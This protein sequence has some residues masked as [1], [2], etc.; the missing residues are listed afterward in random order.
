[1]GPSKRILDQLERGRST[2][3][4]LPAQPP[5]RH[6]VY[7]CGLVVLVMAL[8]TGVVGW[9]TDSAPRSAS[10]PVRDPVFR[11]AAAPVVRS[12]RDAERLAAA[13]VNEPLQQHVAAQ[14]RQ[15]ERMAGAEA[16]AGAGAAPVVTTR[17]AARAAL[18][19]N[20]TAPARTAVGMAKDSAG[21]MGDSDVALLAALM[22]HANGA[23]ASGHAAAASGAGKAAAAAQAAARLQR[24]ARLAGAQAAQCQARACAGHWG[25]S[26]ACR[27]T[28][29]E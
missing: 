4:S 7:A 18:R 25:Q 12:E 27:V 21:A 1:V 11:P 14:S 10:A 8:A 16:R 13:I 3:R 17:N 29:A 19:P 15:P 22:A 23:D 2:V 6:A 26:S 20:A 24:C 9:G 28:V 5:G